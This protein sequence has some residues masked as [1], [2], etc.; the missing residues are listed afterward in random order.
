MP[1]MSG[2]TPT[3]ASRVVVRRLRDGSDVLQRPPALLLQ[4]FQTR[5]CRPGAR[6][7]GPRSSTVQPMSRT[8][9]RIVGVACA[10][11]TLAVAC[12]GGD[13]SA[14]ETTVPTPATTTTPQRSS[15]NQLTI[16]LLLPS[17]DPVLGQNP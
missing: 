10:I 16:G 3:A 11:A 1:G 15:D 6:P 13:N 14:P 17:S 12:T 2:R 5:P 8:A 9:L 4:T 7:E